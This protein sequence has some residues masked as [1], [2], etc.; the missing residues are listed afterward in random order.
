MRVCVAGVGVIGSLFAA[1]LS[2]VAEVSALTRR[3]E[4]AQAL[5]EHGLVVTGRA[6]F[7]RIARRRDVPG[8]PRRA[9][10]RDRGVQGHR[11]R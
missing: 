3:E 1:H 11:S 4:H 10:A 2:R 7:T 6:D 5:R 9:R 8:R